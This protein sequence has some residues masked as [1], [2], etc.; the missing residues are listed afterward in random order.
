MARTE[1]QK[2]IQRIGRTMA[3]GWTFEEAADE[4][5]GGLASY[6]SKIL[7]LGGLALA[8]FKG[9]CEDLA[10]GRERENGAL[11]RLA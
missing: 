6:T 3:D 4:T 2:A 8:R 5:R 7:D 1:R 11:R 9:A 10:I